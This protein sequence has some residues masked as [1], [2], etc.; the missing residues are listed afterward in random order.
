MTPYALAVVLVVV[1]LFVVLSLLPALFSS[2]D[3]DSLVQ[4]NK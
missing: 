2:K 1:G 3:Y 4:V